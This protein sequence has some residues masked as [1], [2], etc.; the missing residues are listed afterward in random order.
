MLQWMREAQT[1]FIKGVLG[2]VVLAFVVTIFYQWGVRSSGG[3]TRSEVATIFG[4]P[5]NMRDFQRMY[6]ALQQRYRAI[7]RTQSTV[8][9]NERFNFREMAL[10]QLATRAILLRLAQ[11]YGV[12]VTE[13]ELYDYIAGMAPFQE[14]GQFSPARYQLV[15]RSQVPPVAPRQFETEQQRELLLQKVSTLFTAGVQV[16]DAEVEQAYRRDHEQAAVRYVILPA[17]LFEAQVTMTDEELQAYYEAHKEGYREPEQR[18]IRY[19]AIPLQR[20]T[21]HDDPTSEEISDYYARHSEAFQRLEQVRA[22]HILVQVTPSASAEQE[23]QARTRAEALLTSLR[24]GEDFA[25]LAQQHSEDTA[26]AAKGGDLGY[27]PRGQMVQPFEDA[28]FS[29]PVGQLSEL[30]RSPFGWHILRVEDKHEAAIK[31]LAEVEQE[32]RDKLRQDK[33]RD[34]VAA[35]VDDLLTALEANPQQFAA[36]AQQHELEVV[37]TPFIA[38]TGQAEGLENVPDLVK[39]VFA[40]P[41]LGVDTLQGQDGTSYVFQTAAI[42]PAMIQEF[43][44]VQE[45]V[46]QELRLQKSNELAQQQAEDWATKVR[47][48]TPLADLAAGLS[49]QVVETGLLKRRDPIPQLGQQVDFSRVA[50]GLQVGDAGAAHDSMRH[51]VIQVMERQPADMQAYVT[52]K[53]EYRQKLLEQKRQQAAL[54]F[55][56]FVHAQ[57]QKL[58]QQGEIVVNPQY[59]F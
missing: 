3:P 35:F 32:V 12:V 30:V 19:V 9:L 52:G 17:S 20:F 49:I 54:A 34:A 55:Q 41:E 45:R 4:Q 1:W 6:N 57:Y 25:T 56:Q 37:T 21:Q 26:T 23:E 33:A 53:P 43:S 18:Q 48:G 44:A 14:H 24:N 28:A 59:V 10:E 22:R 40:L 7:F 58:R 39:R 47:T 13:Q 5:V 2:A 15:L 27:F 38:A 51:F 29:L 8:D 46:T 31:P 36:L 16:T 50:F 11:Q 42:H